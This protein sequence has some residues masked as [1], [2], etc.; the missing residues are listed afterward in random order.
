MSEKISADAINIIKKTF[1]V[2][3]NLL[4]EFPRNA[5]DDFI[6]DENTI[7]KIKNAQVTLTEMRGFIRKK[8]ASLGKEEKSMVTD[9]LKILGQLL[10]E[11]PKDPADEFMYDRMIHQM[12]EQARVAI[13]NLGQ[14]FP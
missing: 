5:A 2:F 14:F 4:K 6:Y 8:S 13:V 11:L 10:D 1:K 12:V 3:G 9:A 7:E